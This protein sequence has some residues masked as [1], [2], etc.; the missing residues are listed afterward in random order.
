MKNINAI[1]KENRV[2]SLQ[3]A[4]LKITENLV[5][6][7]LNA[8][9]VIVYH[10][11]GE[12]VLTEDLK[13]FLIKLL[14]AVKHNLENTLIINDLSGIKFKQIL[15]KTQAKKLI[16]FGSTRNHLGLN[17]N[18]KRYKTIVIQDCECI[19]VDKLSILKDDNQRKG[20]L[21]SLMK[22]MFNIA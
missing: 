15:N 5:E 4:D 1:Y 13:Q 10:A 6:G 22:T 9:L 17:L 8:D 7:N 20:A 12:N 2:Y 18:L 21:W 3:K 19:F 11:E 14:G 16:V